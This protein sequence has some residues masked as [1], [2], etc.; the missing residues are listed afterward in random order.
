M[1]KCT[2]NQFCAGRITLDFIDL[3]RPSLR[4]QILSSLI[5]FC[6]TSNMPFSVILHD[7]KFISPNFV[8]LF[9]IMRLFTK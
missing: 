7:N 4:L 1:K 5:N 3:K 8:H 6:S 2:D 9:K